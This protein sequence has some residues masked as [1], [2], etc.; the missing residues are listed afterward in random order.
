MSTSGSFI[1]NHTPTA[2]IAYD[3]VRQLTMQPNP[4]RVEGPSVPWALLK[5]RLAKKLRVFVLV[6][7][8]SVGDEAPFMRLVHV[9][10]TSTPISVEYVLTD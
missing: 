4:G 8:L 6:P 9:R 10:S 2:K 5:S 1:L 7:N 3:A